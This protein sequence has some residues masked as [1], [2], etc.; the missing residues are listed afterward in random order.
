MA[1]YEHQRGSRMMG[2]EGSSARRP[3]GGSVQT[4]PSIGHGLIRPDPFAT[5]RIEK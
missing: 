1:I 4:R 3:Q 5:L 2:C